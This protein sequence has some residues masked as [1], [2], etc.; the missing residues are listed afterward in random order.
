MKAFVRGSLIIGIKNGG[1]TSGYVGIEGGRI[2]SVT[3]ERPEDYETAELIVG[4]ENRIVSPAFITTA[5]LSLYPFRYRVYSG[6][7]NLRDLVS[8][9]SA[10]D[11]YSFS[12]AASYHLLKNGVVSVVITD[13]FVEQAARA[14]TVVGLR[15]ILVVPAGCYSMEKD[16]E[17]TFSVLSNRW[18]SPGSK[19][20]VRV[21]DQDLLKDTLELARES[22]TKVLAER[23]VELSSLSKEEVKN[24]I[25]LGGGSR[26]DIEFVKKMRIPLSFTPSLEVSVFPL[27]TLHP[28]IAVD[29]TPSYNPVI[30][31][32]YAVS[33][34]L[35]TSEDAFFSLTKW[36][37][38]QASI[39]GGVIERSKVADI[40]VFEYNE[41]PSFPLDYETP[42]DDVIFASFDHVETV[43]E[44]G[45]VILDGGV[46]LNVG[47]KDLEKALERMRGMDVNAKLASLEKG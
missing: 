23:T 26:S 42:W 6:K 3:S 39:D 17:S 2:T 1:T 31:A 20:F 44:G 35:L 37:Y 32:G 28:S 7:L 25:A 8:V 16:W 33:R 36:G 13:P 43:F 45:E 21:C 40:A 27:S 9:M 18:S 24:L 41:P 30:E 19:V 5:T 14:A 11:A 12:L 10:N 4:G 46:P 22:G 47:E 34:L 29:L 15:P 38:E